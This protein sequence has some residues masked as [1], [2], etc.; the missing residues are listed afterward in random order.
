[1]AAQVTEALA[2]EKAI[3]APTEAA[4]LEKKAQY[5]AERERKNAAV[6]RKT[7]AK[8]RSTW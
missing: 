8:V 3:W 2:V 1:M 5:K 7:R 4:K 6:K